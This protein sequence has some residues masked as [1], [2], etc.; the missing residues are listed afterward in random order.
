MTA[1]LSCLPH[2]K[3]YNLEPRL[4]SK[5]S[6]SL[7][8]GF[9][10][11]IEANV[12]ADKRVARDAA[13][14]L[15]KVASDESAELEAEQSEGKQVNGMKRV[16]PLSSTTTIRR[17]ECL[18]H[19]AT[20]SLVNVLIRSLRHLLLP[21]LKRSRSSLQTVLPIPSVHVLLSASKG[22]IRTRRTCLPLQR[23]S[24][25]RPPHPARCVAGPARQ[26]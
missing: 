20:P 7:S 22:M 16:F 11:M 5:M 15:T 18:L 14:R 26:W 21:P 24:S 8:K 10:L 17:R 23:T 13:T 25:T 19:V 3:A 1:L 6:G 12:G 4:S 9:T 2:S